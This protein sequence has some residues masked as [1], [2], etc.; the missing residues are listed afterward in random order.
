MSIK[1]F[2]EVY[3]IKRLFRKLLIS[4]SHLPMLPQHRGILLKIAGVDIKGRCLI[5]NNVGIDTVYPEKIHIGR[6]VAITTGTHILTHYLDPSKPN[7]IFRKGDVYIGDNVFIGINTII[8]NGITIG[9]GAI[10][11][12]GSVV[13]KDIPPYQCWGGNPAKYIKDRAK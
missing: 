4:L 11:G 2:K 8:C 9:E 7:R 10:I 1:K 6:N 5:Y 12:A 13:T 3:P